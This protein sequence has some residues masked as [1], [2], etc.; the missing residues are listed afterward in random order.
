[1]TL[2]MFLGNLQLIYGGSLDKVG[3]GNEEGTRTCG[4]TESSNRLIF[5]NAKE[6]S[7]KVNFT[8][9][10]IFYVRAAL[11]YLCLIISLVLFLRLLAFY[12]ILIASVWSQAPI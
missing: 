12:F 5:L 2:Y 8:F 9:N 10:E 4:L 7:L 6:D 11:T 3:R 1:M